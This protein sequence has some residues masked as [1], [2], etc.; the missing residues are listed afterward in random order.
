MDIQSKHN[1]ESKVSII[2][3]YNGAWN[4]FEGTITSIIIVE[5]SNGLHESY[6]VDSSENMVW[7]VE[8]IYLTIEEAQNVCNTRNNKQ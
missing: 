6:I 5:D 8:D 1:K 7:D 2:A 4:A 3:L